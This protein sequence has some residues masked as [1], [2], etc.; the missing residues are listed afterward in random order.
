[1]QFSVATKTYNFDMH[2][3]YLQNLCPHVFC[4]NN[5]NYAKYLSLYYVMLLNLPDESK[6]LIVNKGFSVSRSDVPD[7]RCSINMTIEQTI[8][9][10]AKTRGG[11]IGFS[12]SLSIYYRWCVTLS[13]WF[14]AAAKFA[15]FRNLL[16]IFFLI[17]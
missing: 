6:S 9:K 11:I 3:S 10:D 8:N 7:G 12:R 15:P 4:M 1:M 2:V 17:S 14:F 16:Q 5:H 13:S